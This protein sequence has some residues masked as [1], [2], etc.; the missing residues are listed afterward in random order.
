MHIKSIIEQGFFHKFAIN[1]KVLKTFVE[2]Q[3]SKFERCRIQT[4]SHLSLYITSLKVFTYSDVGSF[5]YS[6]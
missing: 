5:W 6:F 1:N 2:F 3:R 4:L